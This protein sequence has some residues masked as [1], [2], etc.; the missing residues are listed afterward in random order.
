M[1]EGLAKDM[2][3]GSVEVDSAGME[4]CAGEIASAH[5][6]EVLKGQDVDLSRHRSRRITPELMADADW[7]IPMTQVQEE[8]LRRLFPQYHHKIRYL[9]GWGDQKKD[10]LDPFSGSLE[11]YRQTADQIREL[12][13]TLKDPLILTTRQKV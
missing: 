3:G 1:A 11:V 8:T 6:R 9:G 7:I 2:F 5:A 13:S 10:V 4:A 12:L